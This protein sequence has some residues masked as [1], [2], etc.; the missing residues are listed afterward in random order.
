MATHDS[1][2]S[3]AFPPAVGTLTPANPLPQTASTP[4]IGNVPPQAVEGL[5][6]AAHQ[7]ASILPLEPTQVH[8]LFQL[9]SP[10][11]T[12]TWVHHFQL[13]LKWN[14]YLVTGAP[15]TAGLDSND[16]SDSPRR[17]RCCIHGGLS[18]ESPS[19]SEGQH[20]EA[21]IVCSNRFRLLL[22]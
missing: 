11:P 10:Q 2:A 8:T 4:L 15:G 9:I 18:W 22:S 3:A 19:L 7:A 21:K 14:V 16:T 13:I 17:P 12:H 6:A 1:A 5:K 20:W